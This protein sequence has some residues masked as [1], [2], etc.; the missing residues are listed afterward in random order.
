MNRT[1]IFNDIFEGHCLILACRQELIGTGTLLGS[2]VRRVFVKPEYQKMGLGKRIMDR[3]EEKAVE[4]GVRIMDLDASLVAYP[5]YRSLGYKTQAEDL[6]P[7]E[8][9]TKLKVLQNGEKPKRLAK[10]LIGGLFLRSAA[11]WQNIY[12]QKF[13]GEKRPPENY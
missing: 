10:L 11:A 9:W 6:I 5:F 4:N 2:N 12:A 8:K 1:N 7:S 13:G 3:L